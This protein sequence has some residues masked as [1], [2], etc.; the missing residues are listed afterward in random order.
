M[1]AIILAGGFGTR[2]KHI[3]SDVPKPMAPVNGRPFLEYIL[4]DL[5]NKGITHVVMAVCHMKENIINHFGH[6]YKDINID[7]SIEKDPL[8]TGGAIKQA[9]NMCKDDAFFVI[10]GDTFFD[11]DLQDMKIQHE[12]NKDDLTI[13]VKEMQELD[14]YGSVVVKD[15]RILGFNEKERCQNG[16]IN[17]GIYYMNKAYIQKVE[18]KVFSL[19]TDYIEKRCKNMRIG[20]FV[21]NGYFIDIGVGEDYYRAEKDFNKYKTTSNDK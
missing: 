3:V 17:G 6:K 8:L 7:Y 13:A 4:D 12:Q 11:V 14:R 10:N 18:L 1:E 15:K 5:D 21:S 19:E 16:Y 9:A 2:L 20:A